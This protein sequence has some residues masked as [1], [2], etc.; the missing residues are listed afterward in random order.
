[1]F[2]VIRTGG[3]QYKVA[4]DDIIAVEKLAGDPGAAIELAEVLMIGEGAEV[5]TGTPLLAG[6]SVAATVVDQ[7]RAPKIIVFKKQRRKNYRRKKGHRQY[8][9]VLRIDEIRGAVGLLPAE[10]ERPVVEAEPVTEPAV[11]AGPAAEA[12]PAGEEGALN[13]A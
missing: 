9:T 7:K 8:Q 4:K 12:G 13:G 6:A 10:D 3:K 2:A 11:E 5:A 1:M